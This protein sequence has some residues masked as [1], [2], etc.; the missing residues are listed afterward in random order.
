MGF[1]FPTGALG[2]I[3]GAALVLLFSYALSWGFARV[4]LMASNSETAQVM[5]FPIL[6]PLIF[7]S[8]AFVNPA[9][10]PA[11][12]RTFAAWQP[13]GAVI[14]ACRAL[15]VGGTVVGGSTAS[16]VLVALAWCVGFLVVLMPL[17]VWRYRRT[18]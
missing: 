3:A 4:G 18:A 9:T 17:A 11:W 14:N 1:D 12:M 5:A 15:M 13:V 7:A 10:F 6:F 8:P 16:H 2:F